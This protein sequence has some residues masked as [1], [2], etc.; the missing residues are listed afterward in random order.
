MLQSYVLHWY[1]TYFFNPVTDRT[2]MI[3]F[4]HLYWTGMIKSVRKEVNSCDTCQRTKIS[5]IKYGKFP[6]KEAE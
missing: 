4:Q 5:N 3:I 1:H 2:D 6:D